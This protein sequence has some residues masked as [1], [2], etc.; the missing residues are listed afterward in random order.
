MNVA[1]NYTVLM[2]PIK[3]LYCDDQFNCRGKITPF[4]VAELAKDIEKNGLQFPIAVQPKAD[5]LDYDPVPL[6]PPDTDWRIIAGHRR[7]TALAV[8]GKQ[9]VPCMVK[10]GLTQIQAMVLNLG[11]NLK[12]EDLN[13]L[14]EAIAIERLWRAG[15]PRDHVAKELGKSSGWVQARYALLQLP[16]DIQA[17]A[18]AGF[19]TQHHVKQLSSLSSHEEMYEAVRK[20]KVAKANGQ[21]VGHVGKKKAE[22][23]DVAKERKTHDL[24]AMSEIMAK[25]LGYGIWTRY[26][27]WAA[28]NITT[29]VFLA[30]VKLAHREGLAA[31]AVAFKAGQ[32]TLDDL[33]ERILNDAEIKRRPIQIPVEF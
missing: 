28:G 16:A 15:V 10:R 18:A 7:F 3:E 19:I 5:T 33:G 1:E 11:E 30:D 26:A 12:R 21:K 27:A 25:N 13:I 8:L 31:D 22:K 6:Y 14:Q 4:D 9:D 24:I 20:I 23:L 32:L 29:E 2:I 17:E